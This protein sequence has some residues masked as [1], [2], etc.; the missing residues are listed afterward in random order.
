MAAKCAPCCAPCCGTNGRAT[1]YFTQ[2]EVV[3]KKHGCSNYGCCAGCVDV[4][5]AIP[6]DLLAPVGV[7]KNCICCWE[8][9]IG[10]GKLV[11]INFKTNE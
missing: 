2:E 9:Q 10:H 6:Y 4:E 11:T 3:F 8:A 5:N 1:M 7:A